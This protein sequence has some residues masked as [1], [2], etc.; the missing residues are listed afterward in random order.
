MRG[1]GTI[2]FETVWSPVSLVI[3]E[4]ST[5]LIWS[6]LAALGIVAGWRRRKR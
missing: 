3:P 6:L 4:P 2:Q 1:V 5:L